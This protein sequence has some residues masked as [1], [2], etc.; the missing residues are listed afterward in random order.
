MSAV[1]AGLATTNILYTVTRLDPELDT[2]L[3]CSTAACCSVEEIGIVYSSSAHT[4]TPPNVPPVTPN[5]RKILVINFG[6]TF[7]GQ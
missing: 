7:T 4:F 1:D 2:A 3:H 6:T 5:W